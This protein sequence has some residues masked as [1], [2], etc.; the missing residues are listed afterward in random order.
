MYLI[1]LAS[2]SAHDYIA[3]ASV[4]KSVKIWSSSLL[5]NQ[6][7]PASMSLDT[8]RYCNYTIS[9]KIQENFL[10]TPN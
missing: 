2:H 1:R 5:Q 8:F 7:Q 4:D 3:S 9:L 6:S 10:S